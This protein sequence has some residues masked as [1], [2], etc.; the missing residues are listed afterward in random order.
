MFS[1]RVVPSLLALAGAVVLPLATIGGPAANAAVA[2]SDG[3]SFFSGDTTF[4]AGGH[5][6]AMT[7]SADSHA[8]EFFVSTSHEYDSWTFRSAPANL[9]VNQNTDH[10]TFNAHNSFAPVAFVKLNFTPKQGIWYDCPVGTRLVYYGTMTGSVALV[11][12]HRG[13]KFRAARVRFRSASL[14]LVN[15]CTGPTGVLPCANGTWSIGTTTRAAGGTPGLPGRQT[16]SVRV[17]KN[18]RL[19][20]PAGAI[21]GIHVF[22]KT[23]QP[24]FSFAKKTLRVSGGRSRVISGSALLRAVAPATVRFSPCTLNGKSYRARDAFYRASFRSPRGGQLQARSIV[25]GRIK[26]P[27]SGGAIFDIVTLKR[28]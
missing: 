9:K 27:R 16:Y 15:S 5:V 24:V 1:D 14:T 8:A 26:E 3:V 13:L 20:R 10:A 19:G 6:W 21:L 23:S 25:A 28:A 11:A 7:F 12:N 22:A 17:T 4:H 18:V 2:S